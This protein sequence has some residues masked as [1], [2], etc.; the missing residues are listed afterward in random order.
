MTNTNHNI[1]Y[2]EYEPPPMQI[3]NHMNVTET[4]PPSRVE[5]A[6]PHIIQDDDSA[7]PC[8]PRVPQPQP[9][10]PH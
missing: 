2:Q 8:A 6:A 9:D 1:P 5:K 4:T 7:L 3:P 10:S